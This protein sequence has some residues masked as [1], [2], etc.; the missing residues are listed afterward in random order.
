M[1]VLLGEPA[2]CDQTKPLKETRITKTIFFFTIFSRNNQSDAIESP[3]NI[4]IDLAVNNLVARWALR[5]EAAVQF[6]AR[7]VLWSYRVG[8]NNISCRTCALEQQGAVPIKFLAGPVLCSYKVRC[9]QHLPN[10]L[11]PAGIRENGCQVI[12]RGTDLVSQ[13]GPSFIFF[14]TTPTSKDVPN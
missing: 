12:L 5:S 11:H 9:H 6:I 10:V 4:A 7:P 2:G 1:G 14:I 3:V 13:F 8:A